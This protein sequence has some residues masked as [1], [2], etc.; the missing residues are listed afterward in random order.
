MSLHDTDAR[1]IRKG[2][3]GRPVEFGFKAQVLDNADGIVLD[4][5]VMIGNPP[6][7][8]LLAPAIETPH[9]SSSAGC[10]RAVTADR[11]YGEAKVETEI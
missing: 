6:D 9:E 3:L 5:E 1:P 11:C 4:H 8:P 7:A 10:P 2:R